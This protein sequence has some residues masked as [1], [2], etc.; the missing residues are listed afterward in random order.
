MGIGNLNSFDMWD[1]KRI[2]KSNL[3]QAVEEKDT[4]KGKKRKRSIKRML[5]ISVSLIFV[6]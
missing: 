3:K 1:I 5:V 6:F 2:S 4:A